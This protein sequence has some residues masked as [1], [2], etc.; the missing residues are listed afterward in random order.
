M[1]V[2]CSMSSTV[3]EATSC[4][5][6]MACIPTFCRRPLVIVELHNFT[7]NMSTCPSSRRSARYDAVDGALDAQSDE[8]RDAQA[9]SRSDTGSDGVDDTSGEKEASDESTTTSST[10]AVTKFASVRGASVY[11]CR[12]KECYRYAA[13]AR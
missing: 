5:K 2:Q 9:D 12:D 8:Q 6:D 13:L 3:L 1:V 10:L 7:L 4:A 11:F